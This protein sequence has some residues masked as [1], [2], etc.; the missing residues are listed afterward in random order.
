MM[1]KWLPAALRNSDNPFYEN[2]MIE[3]EK[4][5]KTFVDQNIRTKRNTYSISNAS[6]DDLMDLAETVF[7][8]DKN[9]LMGAYNF[10]KNQSLNETASYQETIVKIIDL[11]FQVDLVPFSREVTEQGY[12]Y[13]QI[14]VHL[15]SPKTTDFTELDNYNTFVEMIRAHVAG[16]KISIEGPSSNEFYF[17]FPIG[18]TDTM[19]EELT[20]SLRNTICDYALQYEDGFEDMMDEDPISHGWITSLSTSTDGCDIIIQGANA[21][22]LDNLGETIKFH[23]PYVSYSIDMRTYCL[24]VKWLSE[25]DVALI[26]FR[27]EI[28]KV[29]YSISTRGTLQFYTSLFNT[30]GFN[31]NGILSLMKTEENTRVGR[32]RDNID[33]DKHAVEGSETKLVS[34]PINADFSAQENIINT[35]DAEGDPTLDT[36]GLFNKLDMIVSS[37]ETAYKKDFLLAFYLDKQH[38]KGSSL[39]PY[40]FTK[41]VQEL[42]MLNQKATD[43]VNLCALISLDIDKDDLNDTIAVPASEPFMSITNSNVKYAD[44]YEYDDFRLRAEAYELNN[45]TYEKFYDYRLAIVSD[46]I[47][48]DSFATD[49]KCLTT[50]FLIEGKRYR[51]SGMS[52][53]VKNAH[54]IQ[55]VVP[56][57]YVKYLTKNIVIK[58]FTEDTEYGNFMLFKQDNVGEFIQISGPQEIGNVIA[59][60]QEV[61][62]GLETKKAFVFTCDGTFSEV[63]NYYL[64]F[65]SEKVESKPA[66][67]VLKGEYTDSQDLQTHTCDFWTIDFKDSE[68]NNLYIDLPLNMNL[69]MLVSRHEKESD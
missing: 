30:L 63:S 68:N 69:M 14:G 42:L 55:A 51:H 23:L 36:V 58:L 15:T 7:L 24:S 67:I 57:D 64:D 41:F 59:T 39:M 13:Q 37:Q 22:T 54:E 33:L 27:N 9:V 19:A 40:E 29:P 43:V 21:I 62:V 47:W 44:V 2:L 49:D 50:K 31:F 65:S 4:E 60:I 61:E 45:S 17:I 26:S 11:F 5:F 10:L 12:T 48:N 53:T 66:R 6:L 8:L 35:L 18:T 32:L 3:V 56:D 52:T 46:R 1:E 16:V 20:Q 28:A 34:V 25:D 38:F